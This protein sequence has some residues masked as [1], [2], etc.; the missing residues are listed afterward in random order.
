MNKRQ[1]KNG[2]EVNSEQ[3]ET[4]L[5]FRRINKTFMLIALLLPA[6]VFA[7]TFL[8]RFSWLFESL[9]N[10]QFLWFAGMLVAAV[11]FTLFR[12][13]IMFTINGLLLLLSAWAVFSIYLPSGDSLPEGRVNDLEKIKILSLNLLHENDSFER[14]IESIHEIIATRVDLNDGVTDEDSPLRESFRVPL[15]IVGPELDTSA[16]PQ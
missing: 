16:V 6:V 2:S 12:S 1:E 7:S 5:S 8:A 9:C 3:A 4:F 13:W 10:F 15:R 14:T 11:G